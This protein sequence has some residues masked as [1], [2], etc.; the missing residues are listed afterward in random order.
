MT[1]R[2]RVEPPIPALGFAPHQRRILPSS[3]VASRTPC[4]TSPHSPLHWARSFEPLG[5]GLGNSGILS[6]GLSGKTGQP[7]SAQYSAHSREVFSGWASGVSDRY[8][9]A[10]GMV[11][12]SSI[13]VVTVGCNIP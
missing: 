3:V 8:E 10:L 9:G 2:P 11:S 4:P 5:W 13:E 6:L 1:S 12:S 7:F